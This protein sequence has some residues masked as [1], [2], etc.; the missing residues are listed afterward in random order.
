VSRRADT[1]AVAY[2]HSA[3]V[4]Y[5]WHQSMMALVAYDVASRQ[6]VVR[7]GWLA[8]KYGTGGITQARNDTVAR[9]LS[10]CDSDWLFWV[11]TD[12]G[13]AP[14][15]VDRLLDA[16]HHTD[17]P[18]VGGLCFMMREV[19]IDGMG[20][21][22]VQPRPTIFAWVKSETSEGFQ[23]VDDYPRD[24][25]VPVAGTGSAF[26]LIHRSALTQIADEF[27]PEWY[28]QTRNPTTGMLLSEDLSFC[29][30]LGAL[31]IPVHVHTGVK[32]THLKQAWVDERLFDR[33]DKATA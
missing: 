12:M 18:V 20:G 27:G 7:G 5:S 6:H 15:S 16:A 17:R 24:Q 8:T 21:M 22:I 2:V 30:R 33:I 14:D 26:L 11:D 13:F 3:E 31:D 32:T 29:V 23:A 10:D 9:F 1:V 19:G 4:T 25:L 28:S